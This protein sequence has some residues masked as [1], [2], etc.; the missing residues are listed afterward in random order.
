MLS[1]FAVFERDELLS[2]ATADVHNNAERI[3][4]QQKNIINYAQQLANLL[5]QL[6]DMG[7]LPVAADC[8]QLLGHMLQQEHR[9]AN[10][11]IWG[12]HL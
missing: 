4:N 8:S 6:H 3:A 12:R 10:I 11:L 9:L 1:Y 2:K 7:D 5:T